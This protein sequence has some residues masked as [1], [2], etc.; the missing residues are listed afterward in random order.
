MKDRF[1][2]LKDT[3]HKNPY[4]DPDTL[5]YEDIFGYLMSYKFPLK[6][7]DIRSVNGYRN[8]LKK[9]ICGNCNHKQ[10]VEYKN[11]GNS[12]KAFSYVGCQGC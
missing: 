5:A 1:I 8:S 6:E 4:N 2:S 9:N 11:N 7:H 3:N 10:E 12:I